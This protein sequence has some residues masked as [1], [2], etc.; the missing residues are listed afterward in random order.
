M[1][2]ETNSA[3]HE[4]CR[5]GR[6]GIASIALIA[7][8]LAVFTIGG[9]V[10]Y[11]VTQTGPIENTFT[12]ATTDIE[13]EEGEDDEPFDHETKKNVTVTNNCDYE[14]YVRATYV[15]YWVSDE[16][17][18]EKVI[19]LADPVHLTKNDIGSAW[20]YRE[21]DG[22]WYYNK[23]LA[24][25]ATSDPFIVEMTAEKVEGRHLVIDVIAETVQATPDTAATE[26]WGFVPTTTGTKEK[27][28]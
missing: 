2:N 25:G 11:L 10:A 1:Y 17:T 4:K 19:V 26:V 14:V 13:I 18:K 7:L 22:Y 23:K 16:S 15:A 27:E 9:T 3:K 20:T 12:P 8:V 28:A 5:I 6:R 24:A 21:E